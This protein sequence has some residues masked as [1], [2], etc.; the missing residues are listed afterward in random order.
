[1]AGNALEPGLNVFWI[2]DMFAENGRVRPEIKMSELTQ[3]KPIIV[4]PMNDPDGIMFPHLQAITNLLPEVFSK[5]YVSV[6]RQTRDNYP[7]YM[8][9][10]DSNEFFQ[11]IYHDADVSVGD[12][13][14]TLFA[15]AA[16]ACD[17]DQILHLCYIDRVAFALQTE[18][19]EAFIAD[20]RSVTQADTPLIFARSDAAWATHPNNY[21]ELENFVTI[22]SR[23]LFGK[24]LDFAWCH[25]VIQAYQLRQLVPLINSRDL[26]LSAEIVLQIKDQVQLR[27]VDWLAWEDPFI[28]CKK[29]EALKKEREQS[30]SETR[31]RLGYVIPTLNLLA[32]HS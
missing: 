13:F 24:L 2:H 29:P 3:M 26:S 20:M 12:D 22:T 4:M 1:V 19:K 6:P 5:A 27:D 18:H 32:D 23:H 16:S 30:V 21:R 14:L 9:W 7:N 31:K 28:L 11:P 15:Y 10:L 25:L 8:D 17:P